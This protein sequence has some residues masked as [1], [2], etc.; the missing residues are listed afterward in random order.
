M[1]RPTSIDI[2]LFG[3]AAATAIAGILVGA[4]TDRSALSAGLVALAAVTVVAYQSYFT[5][6][7][8]VAANEQAGISSKQVAMATHQ[9]EL[10]QQ[11]L[12]GMTRPLMVDVPPG[13]PYPPVSPLWPLNENTWHIAFVDRE[14][15]QLLALA[16]RNVG[17]GTALLTGLSLGNDEVSWVGRF[18]R[19]VVPPNETT[20]IDFE[21]PKD[22]D[23]LTLLRSALEPSTQEAYVRVDI[24]YTDMAGRRQPITQLHL[25]RSSPLGWHVFQLGTVDADGE[26]IAMSGPVGS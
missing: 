4:L 23:D 21:V 14:G 16:V 12:E 19:T 11:T 7:A 20:V 8:V 1:R 9:V 6:L 5:R 3:F 17:A 18:R 24:G 15:A 25:R 10:S 2:C 26:T 22:R 13:A